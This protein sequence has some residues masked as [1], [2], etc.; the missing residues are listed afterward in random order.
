M[1]RGVFVFRTVAASDVS[2]FAAQ[3]QMH[4]SVAKLEALLAT[5]GFW[6]YIFDLIGV[7]TRFSHGAPKN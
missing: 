5:V 4:P 3:S 7:R 1:L 2:A 6:L